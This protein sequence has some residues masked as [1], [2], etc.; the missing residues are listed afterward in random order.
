MNKANRVGSE[1]RYR[2]RFKSRKHSD[3]W[4]PKAVPP[5]RHVCPPSLKCGKEFPALGSSNN[6]RHSSSLCAD[7]E[8]SSDCATLSLSVD[9]NVTETVNA[10]DLDFEVHFG[11]NFELSKIS[12]S[13]DM[14]LRKKTISGDVNGCPDQILTELHHHDIR[15]Q[16]TTKKDGDIALQYFGVHPNGNRYKLTKEQCARLLEQ[17][18]FRAPDISNLPKEVSFS[19]I[20]FFLKQLSMGNTPNTCLMDTITKINNYLNAKKIK[21]SYTLF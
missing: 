12:S 11:S 18:T 17:K 6:S 10:S 15:I 21:K 9:S 13:I 3:G 8:G 4:P 19:D 2:P 7:D 16:L 14:T 20:K 5:K 1:L